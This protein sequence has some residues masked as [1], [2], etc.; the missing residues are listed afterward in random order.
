[1][2]GASTVAFLNCGFSIRLSVS[3]AFISTKLRYSIHKEKFGIKNN[4]FPSSTE[5][6][7]SC[8]MED[9]PVGWA[10]GFISPSN[11]LDGGML[12][13]QIRHATVKVPVF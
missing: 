5:G 12:Y 10:S 2:M 11:N 8:N 6:H 4:P 13:M 3:F 7:H 9:V 1:M